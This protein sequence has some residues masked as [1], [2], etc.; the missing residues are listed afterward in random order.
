[1]PTRET[2]GVGGAA[3]EVA[4]HASRIARL[5]L[6]LALIELKEKAAALLGGIVLGLGAAVLALF[7]LGF[8]LATIAAAFETFL[9]TW[10]SLLIVAAVLLVGAG[11]LGMLAI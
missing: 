7:G 11:L 8:A 5:E 10:L 6:D 2:E 9:P 3:K 1:M 4:Q